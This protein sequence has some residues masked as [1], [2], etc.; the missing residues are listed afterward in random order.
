LGLGWAGLGWAGLGWAG[1]G[2]KAWSWQGDACRAGASRVGRGLRGRRAALRRLAPM[3]ARRTLRAPT[4]CHPSP[5]PLL[6][7]KTPGGTCPSWSRSSRRPTA[8]TTG[9]WRA[10][11][12]TSRSTASTSAA[13]R[14]GWVGWG[15]WGK[16]PGW[17]GRAGVARGPGVGGGGAARG[18]APPQLPG[19]RAS[20]QQPIAM[21]PNPPN[22]PPSPPTPPP[23]PRRQ[24][25]GLPVRGQALPPRRPPGQGADLPGASHPE[26]VG[27][28]VHAPRA[29]LRRQDG[30]GDLRGGGLHDARGAVVRGV[31]RRAARH[32]RAHERARGGGAWG[33]GG[34]ALG[35]RA[36]GAGPA[37]AHPGPRQ[38]R[39]RAPRA[40]WLA[41]GGQQ[42]FGGRGPPL[43]RMRAR[44]P[45][46][47]VPPRV[48]SPP[49][50]APLSSSRPPIRCA[51]PPPTATSPGGWATR[52]GRSTW[53]PRTRRPPRRLRATW[54]IPVTTCRFCSV[55][56]VIVNAIAHTHLKSSSG[57][58][59]IQG[60]AGGR[61]PARR[62]RG[63]AARARPWPAP[64]A[65]A[66]ARLEQRCAPIE[67]GAGSDEPRGRGCGATGGAPPGNPAAL[68]VLA[69]P[70]A[71]CHE[72]AR[73]LHLCRPLFA[74]EPCPFHS[75]GPHAE[76]SALEDY[77][78]LPT[79]QAYAPDA[80]R[81]SV[82][83]GSRRLRAVLASQAA[84]QQQ[85]KHGPAPAPFA[86]PAGP[87][88]HSGVAGAADPQG[89]T[90]GMGFPAGRRGAG[91]LELARQGRAT[92]AVDTPRDSNLGL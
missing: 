62:R 40:G 57:G 41:A 28:R 36:Q 16:G 92:A 4:T 26:G 38:R 80:G 77:S 46:R 86:A 53:R 84:L 67:A 61:A 47:P 10:S 33:W 58:P 70:A 72:G 6:P 14:V 19:L 68:P 2:W 18:S 52:R 74:P 1:L 24:D 89:A 42:P 64:A 78:A 3:A 55:K 9:S 75:Y 49:V 50:R 35:F 71:A 21:P 83:V 66:W 11:A 76:Q 32:V 90:A 54:R 87:W 13:A 30:G 5:L 23:A 39:G 44:A 45:T 20:A 29:R 7:P 34:R 56:P 73:C 63:G 79:V 60:A 88:Q 22:N 48:A 8:P 51:C 31:P 82:G 59:R 85:R 91:R 17:E 69:A 12:A 43:A 37:A 25:R 27:R 15:V 65:V 81:Q